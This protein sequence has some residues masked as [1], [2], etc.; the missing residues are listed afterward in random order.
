MIGG[1]EFGGKWG[2]LRFLRWS[3]GAG[4]HVCFVVKR[5]GLI[6]FFSKPMFE[7]IL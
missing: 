2:I 4:E 5:L 6:E 3:D 7:N 1:L